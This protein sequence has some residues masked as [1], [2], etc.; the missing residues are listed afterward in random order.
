M[1]I[2]LVGLAVVDVSVSLLLAA[3]SAVLG[4][5]V[6]VAVPPRLLFKLKEGLGLS[7]GLEAAVVD[8]D[9]SAAVVPV[10]VLP[11]DPK[12]D[13]PGGDG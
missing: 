4:S 9:C 6:D 1:I 2:P 12:R 3:C 8:S 7:P 13:L 10:A 5:A 11:R